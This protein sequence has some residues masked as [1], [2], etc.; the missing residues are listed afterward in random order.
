MRSQLRG[1]MLGD[2]ASRLADLV[3]QAATGS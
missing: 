2:G 1:A 3:E